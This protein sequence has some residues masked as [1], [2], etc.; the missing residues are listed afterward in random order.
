MKKWLYY[1]KKNQIS[2]FYIKIQIQGGL[3]SELGKRTIKQ[4]KY[5]EGNLFV[6]AV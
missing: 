6:T 3:K 1:G 5:V 4:T 2:S